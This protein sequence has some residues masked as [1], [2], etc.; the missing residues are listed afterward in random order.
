MTTGAAIGGGVLGLLSET[1]TGAEKDLARKKADA[2][3]AYNEG[4]SQGKTVAELDELRED[5]DEALLLEK[6]VDTG[7]KILGVDFSKPDTIALATTGIIELGLLI[8]GGRK[9]IQTGKKYSAEKKGIRNA[10]TKSEN[11]TVDAATVY[12]SI[13]EERIKLKIPVG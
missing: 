4:V 13:G 7:K 5:V 1:I 2:I 8:F 3:A 10:L 9:L 6:G 12:S 11:G